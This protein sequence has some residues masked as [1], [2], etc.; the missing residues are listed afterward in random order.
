MTRGRKRKTDKG[1]FK[2]EQMKRAGLQVIEQGSSLRKAADQNNVK[3]QTLASYVKKAETKCWN[4]DVFKDGNRI[5]NL[6]ETATTT[7]QKMCKV[8]AVRGTKQVSKATSGERDAPPG[9]LGLV[10]SS[11]WMTTDL[12]PDVMKHFIKYSNSSKENPS[13]LVYDNH[14][15]HL[16]ITALNIAKENG[17]IILTLPP[18]C[19]HKMQP[20]DIN[21][22]YSF[23]SHFNSAVD[24]WMNRN[25][26]LTVSIYETGGFVSI[27]HDRSMNPKN[28]KSGFQKS[29]IFPFDDGIF[30]DDDFLPCSVTDRPMQDITNF[31]PTKSNEAGPSKNSN[32]FGDN[33]TPPNQTI[34]PKLQERC[35]IISNILLCPAKSGELKLTPSDNFVTPEMFIGYPKA[36]KRKENYIKR[37]R[38]RSFIPTDTPEKD[39]LEALYIE[40]NKKKRKIKEKIC[41]NIFDESTRTN[42]SEESSESD[43]DN[44]LSDV[45]SGSSS[46][47]D[48]NDDINLLQSGYED[49][50]REL[51]VDD[52]IL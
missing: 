19:S 18:H 12:F 20:L 49:L 48:I 40:R 16:S 6:D 30:T 52:F 45:Y 9:T 24:T 43:I 21:V 3:F 11:G 51:R 23:K 1:S 25:P 35:Q 17:V 14:E 22:F 42:I 41:K 36:K 33:S 5:Y 37:K 7:V 2:E 13:L 15:S 8:V 46:N 38:G 31:S 10:S 27:A 4:P 44:D 26:A 32:I 34:Q 47:Y 28:I 39:N 29:G 50:N